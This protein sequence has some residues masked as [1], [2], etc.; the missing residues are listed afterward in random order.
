MSPEQAYDQ[1]VADL[2]V[3]KRALFEEEQRRPAC[4]IAAIA[5]LKESGYGMTEAKEILSL[6]PQYAA[7][8]AQ[9]FLL[10]MEVLGKEAIAEMA[11]AHLWRSVNGASVV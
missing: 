8:K 3:A 11:K 10:E 5:N 9:V 7:H 1:A 2:I 6:E 4:R